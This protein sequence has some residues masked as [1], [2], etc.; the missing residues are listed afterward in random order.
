M[1]RRS[2]A[3]LAALAVVVVAAVG[4]QAETDIRSMPLAMTDVHIPRSDFGEPS[5]ALT[6]RGT[7]LLCG[8]TGFPGGRNAFLRSEDWVDFQRTDVF[9]RTGGGDCDLKVGPDGAIYT[10][11]LQLWASA[12]RKSVDDGLTFD[13]QSTEDAVEQDR[14]WLATDPVDGSI[15]YMG[16]HDLSVGAIVIAKSLDGARTFPIHSLVSTDP[17]HVARSGRQTFPGPVRVDPTAHERVYMVWSAGDAVDCVDAQDAQGCAFRPHRK[18]LVGRSE[19]GGLTWT[20]HVAMEAPL[21]SKLS[22]LIPWM[23]VDDAGN[24]YVVAAG[25]VVD[26]LT[27]ARTNGLFMAASTD[28]GTS[29]TGPIKVNTGTGAVVFPAVIAGAPGVVDLAWVESSVDDSDDIGGVWRLG[30]AQTRNA[31]AA[32]PDFSEVEGP[33]VHRGDVCTRG[34]LCTLGGDRTLLDFIDIT[35]DEF[36]FAHVAATSTEPHPDPGAVR[37]VV[38]WRQDAGPSALT[39]P[40]VPACVSE[41]PIR[42]PAYRPY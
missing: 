9:D 5:I 4:V 16:Y 10:A 21:G 8:P 14:Q 17:I 1:L 25:W 26:P 15:V 18:V 23:T 38:W 27:G 35:L 12:V 41:R 7:V 34:L 2:I 31:N 24:L 6:R 20:N 37:H 40:C 22:N 39:E 11:N 29:W 13:Y 3:G 32:A 28:R 30:F 36:G 42:L 33:I 19:D